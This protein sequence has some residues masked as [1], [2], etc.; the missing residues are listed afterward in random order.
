MIIHK[1]ED[2]LMKNIRNFFLVIYAFISYRPSIIWKKLEKDLINDCNKELLSNQISC[3][4]I[5]LKTQ[6]NQ[7]D[8]RL[9]VE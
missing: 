6:E 4:K 7:K 2:G 3:P 9:V 1:L 5:F 8:Q